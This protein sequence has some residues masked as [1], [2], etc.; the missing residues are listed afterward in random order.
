M[1]KIDQIYMCVY[2]LLLAV[3]DIR[4]RHIPV[5]LLVTGGM[6]GIIVRII[7]AKEVDLYM[8]AGVAVGLIF[9]LISRLTK[10]NFGYGDSLLILVMGICMGIWDM[11][12]VLLLAFF[13][14]ALFAVGVLAAKGFHEKASFPFVPFLCVSYILCTGFG[15]L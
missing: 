15:G 12:G 3:W 4:R 5:C 1:F 8:F 13:L 10:E 9:L 2:L 11:A 6:A 7:Q 14:S